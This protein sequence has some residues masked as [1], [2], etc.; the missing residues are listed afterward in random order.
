MSFLR[1]NPNSKHAPIAGAVVWGLLA[2]ALLTHFLG[3]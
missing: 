1:P 2:L 3:C